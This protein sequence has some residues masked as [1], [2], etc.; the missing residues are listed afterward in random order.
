LL[1]LPS[2]AREESLKE[3]FEFTPL[4][5]KA[6]PDAKKKLSVQIVARVFIAIK[7]GKVRGGQ[8]RRLKICCKVFVLCF[9]C[10]NELRR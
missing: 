8:G 3:M 1:T 7:C 6:T 10:D 2:T 9:P 5:L 4:K